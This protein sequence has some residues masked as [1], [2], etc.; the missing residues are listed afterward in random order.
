MAPASDCPLS[1]PVRR[2]VAA[3]PCV[4][5]GAGGA[6]GAGD[7]AGAS[8]RTCVGGS[9]F[10][11]IFLLRLMSAGSRMKLSPPA[12]ALALAFAMP[13]APSQWVKSTN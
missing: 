9:T 11:L 2:A 8:S 1:P 12:N 10:W 5:R 13:P 7:V 4:P 6:G 3:M